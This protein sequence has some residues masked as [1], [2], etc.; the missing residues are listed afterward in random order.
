LTVDATGSAPVGHTDRVSAETGDLDQFVEHGADLQEPLLA[1]WETLARQRNHLLNVGLHEVVERS[2]IA[3]LDDTIR[4]M[5]ELDNFVGGISAA[6]QRY[7]ADLGRGRFEA[8]AVVIDRF[9]GRATH[10]RL[11]DFERAMAIA[12]E[13]AGLGSQPTEAAGLIRTEIEAVLPYDPRFQIDGATIAEPNRLAAAIVANIERLADDLIDESRV[14]S[15]SM[16]AEPQLSIERLAV[17]LHY[18]HPETEFAPVDLIMAAVHN[19]LGDGQDRQLRTEL[20]ELDRR[21]QLANLSL[22]VNAPAEVT[23]DGE[24]EE[25]NRAAR[26]LF[27]RNLI[28]P[29]MH[30][31]PPRVD[32]P[33]IA[34]QLQTVAAEN[35]G[36]ALGLKLMLDPFVTPHQRSEIDRV[37]ATG[38]S[39]GDRIGL[40]VKHPA[41]GVTGAAKGAYNENFGWWA[42]LWADAQVTITNGLYGLATNST[43][44]EYGAR[45]PETW[46]ENASVVEL[47]LEID[48]AAQQGGADLAFAV[49]LASAFYG[50]GKAGLSIVRIGR[51]YFLRSGDEL[52]AE[53]GP[54]L[55]AQLDETAETVPATPSGRSAPVIERTVDPS[56]LARRVDVPSADEP[57]VIP[58]RDYQPVPVAGRP[59]HALDGNINGFGR[60]SGGHYLR[61]TNLR[62]VRTIDVAPNGVI[63]AE[64]AIR[65]PGGR[66][67][68][69]VDRRGQAAQT[70]LFPSHW[71]RRRVLMEIDWAFK[72]SSAEFPLGQPSGSQG[73]AAPEFWIGEA[74]DGTLIRGR[75]IKPGVPSFGWDSAYPVL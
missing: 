48:N 3:T 52:L 41:D 14:R 47:E 9:L 49:E 35:P 10:Q 11:H 26:D 67:I 27:D 61:S 7:G 4:F 72:N 59:G 69:R 39:L 17:E 70:T 24:P 42:D 19:R 44:S 16:H 46:Q 75:Y 58:A 22:V 18:G 15:S 6:L 66:W 51:R 37:L 56:D 73:T 34:Y 36:R 55:A 32:E 71:S 13:R 65:G 50:G 25:L 57:V 1:M 38:G 12:L 23:V 31:G 30:G 40:A 53:V 74:S 33:E 54:K 21:Q 68:P 8:P 2:E 60:A 62:V 45:V 64:I 29:G 28:D 20:V 5:A 63:R 43:G